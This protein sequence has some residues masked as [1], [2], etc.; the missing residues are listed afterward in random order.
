MSQDGIISEAS[1]L[2]LRQRVFSS[3]S[4]FHKY[5]EEA[6]VIMFVNTCIALVSLAVMPT[7]WIFGFCDWRGILVC[8]ACAFFIWMACSV[9]HEANKIKYLPLTASD[10]WKTMNPNEPSLSKQRDDV[11]YE[12][13]VVNVKAIEKQ[14]KCN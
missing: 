3:G 14:N 11:L 2:P 5:D 6:R 1:P 10:V 9:G 12:F 13:L 7:P 4:P 8:G